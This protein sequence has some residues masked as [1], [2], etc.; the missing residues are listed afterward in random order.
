MF[1]A[2]EASGYR[3]HYMQAFGSLD[4]MLTGRATLAALAEKGVRR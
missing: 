3:G 1:A 4:D 2:I